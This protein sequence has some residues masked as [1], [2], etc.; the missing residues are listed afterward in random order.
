MNNKPRPQSAFLDR[1]IFA[2][3][4]RALVT[5]SLLCIG[6]MIMMSAGA[7]G[8]TT[9]FTD[10]FSTNTSATYTTSGAIGA[11]SWSVTRSGADW[12]ARRN[13][14]PAQL[15]LTNDVDG[16]VANANGW[17]FAS[18]PLSGF[19]APYNPTLSSN[20]G[21]V[22][23]TFNFRTNRTA[24]FLTGFTTN[25]YGMAFVLA[26]TSSSPNTSG[27]GYA[28]V[29]GG[30][31]SA[32]NQI[33]LIRFTNG[34]QGT[35]TTVVAFGGAPATGTNYLSVKV[36]YNPS[37]NGW[38]LFNRDDGASA[39]AD[40]TTGSLTSLGTGTDSTF[41][42][43]VMSRLGAY[44]QGNT[45]ANQTAF[46]DNATVTVV[47]AAPTPT[48][49]A[50]ATSTPTAT[51]TAT[52]TATATATPTAAPATPSPTPTATA[53]ATATPT[54]TAT[55]TPTATPVTTPSP[56]PT[57]TA[58]A[59]PTATAT[60][61]ATSTPTST[62]TATATIAPTAT[63]TA[64]ST[65]IATATSTPTAT[66]TSTPTATATATA[67]STSTPTAT[68]TA[69]ATP[70][71]TSSPTPTATATPTAMATP[72]AT[73]APSVAQALNIATRLKVDTGDKAM[74]AGFIINGNASKPVILRGIG[75]SLLAFGI[76]DALLDP[77][78]DLR[79]SDGSLI[80]SND[81]WKDTQ[82]EQIEGGPLQPRDD[83]ESVIVA[84]LPPGAYTAAL[85]GKNNTI[86][87]GLV[88]A[89]DNNQA[90]DSQLAN[91]STRGFVL[92]GNNVMIGGFILGGS[93]NSTR[94]ALRGIGPSL[95]KF[96]LNPVLQDPT[97]E[98]HDGNGATL[99]ANDNWTDDSA[100]A[101]QLTASGLAPT[102]PK[103]AGVF[104]TLP[105]GQFTAV[106]A[107][108]NNGTGIGLIE[109]YNLK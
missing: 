44:W 23:W 86:G 100:S 1:R 90:L 16:A 59:T 26:S 36:T 80:L 17:V 8:Q 13:V 14:S 22:T 95:A 62:P 20:P 68:A 67:T 97:L 6:A 19:T 40:P 92:D 66:A 72:T 45:A 4:L 9:V 32:T 109:V 106:L 84:T 87:V 78:L 41:T 64:T 99:V 12:G 61:T 21:T 18:V 85:T 105:P 82:R 54:A 75:P 50:T 27:D 70:I 46:F 33:S 29:M 107:G 103:E 31:P 98:V 58:T 42:S 77:V 89:Y 38:Q 34:L 57:A 102:D 55:A 24:S 53:T 81:N 35:Q 3:F 83:R 60:G 94:I 28:V 96:G 74:I 69:T 79:G 10:N 88:E 91:I 104:I 7:W 30:A 71:T 108:K 15:E 76:N 52:P 48:A 93:P 11:S 47:N 37:T 73:P 39:F 5:R 43:T 56:T 25:T 49:T 63:A 65:P 2:G 51:A 101:A